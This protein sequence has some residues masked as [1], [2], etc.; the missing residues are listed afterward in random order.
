AQPIYQY[1]FSYVAASMRAEWANGAPHATEI[2]YVFD[3]VKARYGTD[4][5]PDDAATARAANLYW[6]AF[7]KTGDPNTTGLPRWPKYDANADVI[8]N[9]TPSGPAAVADPWKTRLD[10]TQTFVTAHQ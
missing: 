9:F 2:P 3:T 7:A 6:S 8:L 4:L 5:T 1:R 10:L